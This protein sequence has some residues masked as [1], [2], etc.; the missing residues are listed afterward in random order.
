MNTENSDKKRFVV[1]KLVNSGI[2]ITPP[3][4]DFILTLDNPEEKVNLIIKEASFNPAFNGHLTEEILKNLSNKEIVKALKRIIIS[5]DTS[6]AKNDAPPVIGSINEVENKI[7]S[8][9]TTDINE[10]AKPINESPTVNIPVTVPAKTELIPPKTFS[11]F[12][13]RSEIVKKEK[14]EVKPIK[15]MQSGFGFNPIAKEYEPEFKILKDPTGKLYTSGVYND[16]YELTLDKYNK[17]HSLMKKR[18]DAFT[19]SNIASILRN[20]QTV[21]EIGVIGMINDIYQTKN[22]HYML[23]IEDLTGS[24]NVLINKNSENQDN[25]NLA[26]KT[27]SDQMVYIQ[28]TY[29]PG[30]QGKRRKGI[31][32]ADVINKIDIPYDFEPNVSPDPLSIALL[33]DTHIGSQ[34]FEEKL[35]NRFLKFLNGN[36]GNKVYREIA[37]KVK[38]IVINGD[39][40]DGVGVYPNQEK[41]LII[42]DIYKQFERAAELISGIPE[43]IKIIYSPGNHDPVRNAIPRPAVPKKYTEQLLN[44]GVKCIGNPAVIKTH[45][46][47]TLVYHGDSIIDMNLLIHGLENDKPVEAMKEFIKCRHLAPMFGKKTQI[48]PISKDWLVI[49]NIPD[50]FHT[51]HVH[52]NGTGKYNHVTLVNS[53]CFQAQ[54]DFMNSFGIHPT[55]GI[56]SMIE[57][58]TLKIVQ[59][60]NFNN[61]I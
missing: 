10:K 3:I 27:I 44:I 42:K 33:S 25:I 52:I 47:N 1:N 28:G 48:A 50:I 15:S 6:Q 39:L 49:D 20:S 35:W 4:L 58:D 5:K 45:N 57:L 12:K 7:E 17:L 8:K 18:G 41:D 2:N 51:G 36:F 30:G 9:I 43:Y 55:P 29:N 38:Y 46:V 60:I 54:T 21:P 11:N 56:V 31:I 26:K 24:I 13:N 19:V 53:G 37:G 32:F 23:A 16:F 22:G 59:P 34:E 61:K 14:D 40:V